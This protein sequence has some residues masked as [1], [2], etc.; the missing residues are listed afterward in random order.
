MPCASRSA[1][2]FS[3]LLQ[4]ID[5]EAA[6]LDPKLFSGLVH[7]SLV[8]LLKRRFG[9]Q[10]TDRH[11]ACRWLFSRKIDWVVQVIPQHAIKAMLVRS[12]RKMVIGRQELGGMPLFTTRPGRH[13]VS[14]VRS[15]VFALCGG[16]LPSVSTVVRWAASS[17]APSSKDPFCIFAFTSSTWDR[18]RGASYGL[19]AVGGVGVGVG[20]GAGVRSICS[21]PPRSAANS[22]LRSATSYTPPPP[23]PPTPR[24]VHVHGRARV[25]PCWCWVWVLGIEAGPLPAATSA[26]RL[27]PG[28][29]IPTK[30]LATSC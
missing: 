16:V 4:V 13:G 22:H 7:R 24:L 9:R 19:W 28:P 23:H 25:W 2:G 12:T 3:W 15:S 14:G 10:T 26:C 18:D 5:H 30:L 27:L 6:P 20:V 17:L 29:T 8:V 21:L 1:C 11:A